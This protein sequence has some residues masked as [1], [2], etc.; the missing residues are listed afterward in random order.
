[1]GEMNRYMNR[2]GRTQAEL[3]TVGE[4]L[5]AILRPNLDL[6]GGNFDSSDS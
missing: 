1:M 4:A 2:E 5:K 6:K 3:T